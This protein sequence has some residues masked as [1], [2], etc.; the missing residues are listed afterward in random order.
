M[1]D[2]DEQGPRKR[3]RNAGD[4]RYARAS[5]SRK[6]I[7]SGWENIRAMKRAQQHPKYQIGCRLRETA[8]G[9]T[10][11]MVRYAKFSADGRRTKD[12]YKVEWDDG[13]PATWMAEA[14]VQPIEETTD[15]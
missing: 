13:N 5:S 10:G 4:F 7:G 3:S 15:A 1:S 9:R 2:T 12:P 11:T 6:A 14:S 8:T